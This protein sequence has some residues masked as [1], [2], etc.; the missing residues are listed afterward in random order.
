MVFEEMVSLPQELDIHDRIIAA[1][2]KVY[3]A[4]AITKDE[5]L[6]RVVETIW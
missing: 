3:R 4:K 2:S 5:K 1:T 6:S